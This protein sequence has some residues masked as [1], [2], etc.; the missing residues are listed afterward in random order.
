M[1][2]VN[3]S[4]L[5]KLDDYDP[6]GPQNYGPIPLS[7][8]IIIEKGSKMVRVITAVPASPALPETLEGTGRCDR[9]RSVRE[10]TGRQSHFP[11]S[12][13][14]FPTARGDGHGLLWHL[15]HHRIQAAAAGGLTE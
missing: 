1:Q 15:R 12:T 9:S 8:P 11:S 7:R 5:P 10:A 3:Y 13:E 14:I 6:E 4:G 2:W